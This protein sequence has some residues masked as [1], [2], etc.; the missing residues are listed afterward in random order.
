MSLESKVSSFLNRELV[1]L[2]GG[3]KMAAKAQEPDLSPM[4]TAEVDRWIGVPLGGAQ[5]KEP[6]ALNDIRRWAQGMQNPNRLYYDEAYAAH[7]VF[8][9]VVAPQSFTV[10]CT[11]GHGAQPAIQGTVPGSHMLLGE[12][13]GGFMG[14]ESVRVTRSGAIEC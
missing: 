12:T 10:C 5:L 14:H 4:D 1:K 11:V 9:E 8:R 7:S 3:T 13:N 2:T 6:I